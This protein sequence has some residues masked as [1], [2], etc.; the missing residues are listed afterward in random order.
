MTEH[1]ALAAEYAGFPLK[2][3]MVSWL[4]A[5]GRRV[6]D[7]G[8]SSFDPGDDYRTTRRRSPVRLRRA[9]YDVAF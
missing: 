4:L 9:K 8:A 3:E 5:Q 1:L 7:L 6:L 2:T